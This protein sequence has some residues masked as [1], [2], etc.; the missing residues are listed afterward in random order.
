MRVTSAQRQRAAS[1]GIGVQTAAHRFGLQFIPLL[2]ERCFFA[3]NTAALQQ[4]K[5]QGS[6]RLLQSAAMRA[7]I[8]ALKGPMRR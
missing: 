4:P 3:V 6:L 1:A 5:V 2:R 7:A 8:A